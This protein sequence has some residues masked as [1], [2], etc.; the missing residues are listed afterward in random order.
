MMVQFVCVL[1]FSFSQLDFSHPHLLCLSNHA[2]LE[3]I[4]PVFRSAFGGF[5]LFYSTLKVVCQ[6]N[7]LVL[8][9][10]LPTTLT[11]AHPAQRTRNM[12]SSPATDP[13]LNVL[14]FL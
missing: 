10:E 3:V 8:S 7:G 13:N 6:M 4:T 2:N 12:E 5:I 9:V 1:A 14:T 11:I